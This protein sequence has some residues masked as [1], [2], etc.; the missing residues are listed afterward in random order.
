MAHPF[1]DLLHEEHQK[2]K[3]TLEQLTSEVASMKEKDRLFEE[4][5]NDLVPHMKGEEKL[6]YPRL[7]QDVDHAM[8][9]A[10]EGIEE[11]RAAKTVLRELEIATFKDIRWDAKLLVFKEMIEHHVKDEEGKVFKDAKKLLSDEELDEIQTSFE[12]MKAAAVDEQQTMRASS[13]RT[14]QAKAAGTGARKET[15]RAADYECA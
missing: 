12:E 1:L 8:L 15:K 6:F 9:N 2:V 10:Y 11:H 4:L 14:R 7:L 5:L 3:D 13:G